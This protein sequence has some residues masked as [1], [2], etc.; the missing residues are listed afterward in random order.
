MESASDSGSV[1]ICLLMETFA[2]F[3]PCSQLTPLVLLMHILQFA[4]NTIFTHT[5]TPP[6]NTHT[7]TPPNNTHSLCVLC[8]QDKPWLASHNLCPEIIFL[9]GSFAFY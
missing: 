9:F 3:N 7:K 4:N 6:N 5:K 1:I 2:S 8:L